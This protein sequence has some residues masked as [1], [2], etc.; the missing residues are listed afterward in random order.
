MAILNAEN[1]A[2]SQSRPSPKPGHKPPLFIRTLVA[3]GAV[4]RSISCSLL[5]PHAIS[6][7]STSRASPPSLKA[8]RQLVVSTLTSLQVFDVDDGTLSLR[9]LTDV[10]L[11]TSVY[12]IAAVSTPVPGRDALVVL[13]AHATISFMQFDDATS[14]LRCAGQRSLDPLQHPSAADVSLR[15]HPR[16]L[17]THAHRRIVAIASLKSQI[18]VF[19]VI[20][21]P[22]QVNAGKI[23]SVDVDGVILSID[24]LEDDGD[25][26]SS[27]VGGDAILVA[28][29]QREKD[30]VIALY[31]VGV[32]RDSTGGLSV[33]FLG[34]MITCAAHPHDIAV[35]RA[36]SKFT[37]QAVSP[38]P[39]AAGVTR[40]PGCPYLFAVFVKGKV[41]A[42]DARSV[43]ASARSGDAAQVSVRVE[44]DVVIPPR[45]STQ[46]RNSP[47]MMDDTEGPVVTATPTLPPP[48]SPDMS[49]VTNNQIAVPRTPEHNVTAPLDANVGTPLAQP[50]NIN[51]GFVTPVQTPVNRL[52]PP[53]TPLQTQ[54]SRRHEGLPHPPPLRH[55][56][57]FNLGGGF[58]T[59]G[60]SFRNIGEDYLSYLYVPA[61]IAREVDDCNGVATAWVDARDHFR[62]DCSD[63]NGLYFVMESGALYALKWSDDEMTGS[64]TFRINSTDRSRPVSTRNFSVEYIGDV[65]PAVSIASLDRRL[66]YVANDGADGCLRRLHLPHTMH[67]QRTRLDVRTSAYIRS[68]SGRTDGG[69][70][71][72][73]VRQEF[74]NLSPIS[75][76]VIANPRTLSNT[77][78]KKRNSKTDEQ[79]GRR[80]ETWGQNKAGVPSGGD[81]MVADPYQRTTSPLSQSALDHVLDGSEH[82]AELIVCSGI[83]RHGSIRLIRPGAPVSIF[84]STDRSFLP[85]NEMWSVRF[86]KTSL[87][88]SAI[89]LTFAQATRLLLSVPAGDD[90][91]DDGE[92]AGSTP[93]I[94]SLIDGTVSTNILSGRRSLCVG[95]IEDGILAQIHED[96]IL[97]IYLKKA[98][99][100]DMSDYIDDGELTESICERTIEWTPPK[101]CFISV[102]T[103]GAGFIL[104]SVIQRR[105]WKCILYLLKVHPGDSALGLC[106]VSTTE[107]AD[108]VS[109][110]EI[111]AWTTQYS[112]SDFAS[113]HL[114]PMAILGTY[115]PSV[116]LRLLGPTMERVAVRR[117]FPWSI[118]A[119]LRSRVRRHGNVSSSGSRNASGSAN[120]SQSQLYRQG[121]DYDKTSTIPRDVNVTLDVMTAVPESLCALEMDGKRL[122]FTGL[123]DGSV[124]LFCL[125]DGHD[126]QK[127]VASPST[128]ASL[129][130]RGHRKL[131]QRPV[132]VKAVAATV[133]TVIIGQSD[134]PWMGISRCGGNKIEWLPLAFRETRALCAY[135]VPGAER[136]FAA[137]ADD[138]AFYI[139]G[140]RRTSS[141]SVRT[142][143]IG[144][145]PRRALAVPYPRDCIVVATSG[146]MVSSTKNQSP[147]RVLRHPTAHHQRHVRHG[148]MPTDP[149][150][151]WHD[152]AHRHHSMSRD[153]DSSRNMPLERSQLLLYHRKQQRLITSIPLMEYELVHV[154][155]NWMDFV[156]VCTSIGAQ[157]YHDSGG[158]KLGKR[159]RLLLFL[160]CGSQPKRKTKTAK[161]VRRNENHKDDKPG[162]ETESRT[163]GR[164][165]AMF[166][167]FI[168]AEGASASTL[169]AASSSAYVAQSSYTDN[170][171]PAAHPSSSSSTSRAASGI[172]GD[173]DDDDD[174]VDFDKTVV[175][176]ELCSEMILPGGLLSGAVSANQD[177]LAVSCNKEVL[178]FMLI[179]SRGVL[180]QV[181]RASARTLVVGLSIKEDIVCIVDRKDSIGFFQLKTKTLKLVR[182]RGDHM[183]RIVSDAVLVD[184]TLAIAVDRFGG[185][186]TIGYERGDDPPR[187]DKGLWVAA[188]KSPLLRSS[189]EYEAEDDANR[190]GSSEAER[191]EEDNQHGQEAPSQQQ[192]QAQQ[193][194]QEDS[195][196]NELGMGNVVA[197]SFLVDSDAS[198]YL[199][200]VD[201]HEIVEDNERDDD[202]NVNNTAAAAAA[203]G[204]GNEEAGYHGNDHSGNE[205]DDAG[206]NPD[207]ANAPQ[208]PNHDDND[209]IGASDADEDMEEDHEQTMSDDEEIDPDLDQVIQVGED[210]GVDVVNELVE[211]MAGE[212]PNIVGGLGVNMN[213]DDDVQVDMEGIPVLPQGGQ[214]QAPGQPQAQQAQGQR[215]QGQATGVRRNL[216]SHHSF[217]MRDAALRLRVGTFSRRNATDWMSSSSS[218][219]S[220]STDRT[221]YDG[222][223]S[224]SSGK[225]NNVK[226]SSSNSVGSGKTSS[227][228]PSCTDKFF[229]RASDIALA[230]TLGGAFVSAVGMSPDCFDLLSQVETEMIMRPE[231]TQ[232]ALLLDPGLHKSVRAAYGD[233][234]VGTVDGD[235]LTQ[236]D[237]LADDVKRDIATRV[238]GNGRGRNR[239]WASGNGSSSGSRADRGPVVDNRD[240]S[241]STNSGSMMTNASSMNVD[242]NGGGGSG[243]GG[244]GSGGNGGEDGGAED[245]V[246]DNVL[247]I[248]GVIQSLCDRVA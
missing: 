52:E 70:Y 121:E 237:G 12:D 189:I 208:D 169:A 42:G 75:D 219:S 55:R 64:I 174:D 137:T 99:N 132:T 224:S 16:I 34:S 201:G 171:S 196:A 111:P 243:G 157:S 149:Y 127:D 247:L 29:L 232:H 112:E 186:F 211:E 179:P 178:V 104:I 66:L 199:H 83:G 20:F 145:T 81:A 239:S 212:G 23:A 175:K 43:I 17:A 139:C 197:G 28:L 154:L 106:V 39:P 2:H 1:A 92:G 47:S 82:E 146:D 151:Q 45:A 89:V 13:S 184:R 183:R 114:P 130:I 194:Q 37:G 69:R 218:F 27:Q 228:S 222:I 164:T 120:G 167:R 3:K 152:G 94:G 31:S 126:H 185:L 173:G 204:Q 191:L 134:R 46:L 105:P 72:L 48:V 11:F 133:G 38:T 110:I 84:A 195:N 244:N 160:V 242:D 143:H 223:C 118:D 205:D 165:R 231:V 73:E 101:D 135:S 125:D 136:C 206:D 71:G 227:S 207:A 61:Y 202:D 97:L 226:A 107:I 14:R 79:F 68:I 140:L 172:G 74:L 200:D 30:Q 147:P 131:G 158:H 209:D 32:S 19:P 63:V 40:I 241:T 163:K 44:D 221:L 203:A 190:R 103:I 156:V 177:F 87:Y 10:M 236:F 193:Q 233:W 213:V 80:S 238:L 129:V 36:T 60:G 116:E 187:V 161:G 21:L 76:F 33:I 210:N 15:T 102:G 22:K 93:K 53:P 153:D 150:G 78:A 119:V 8:C 67:A 41:I 96:G 77:K 62:D 50:T 58:Q 95:L 214:P 234:A 230:G 128:G 26:A 248:E 54:R 51:E 59:G 5:P 170:I 155:L 159:G 98:G 86:T 141:V 57:S 24:F 35:A 138:D 122:I 6:R 166:S 176:L 18:R 192:T 108:E 182:D 142:I 90:E 100:V 115:A 216:V 180:V 148:H 217:N 88:D 109:C 7:C 229:A 240:A 245:I 9:P 181:A 188:M 65:G 144:S 124:V 117:T 91:N 198:E 25:D 215:G 49:R 4:S 123:R 162:R 85:C 225:R 168:A 235:L 220:S 113:P 246:Q 56:G